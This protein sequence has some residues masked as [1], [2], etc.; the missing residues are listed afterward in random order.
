MTAGAL[1]LPRPHHRRRAAA[2]VLLL[3]L[4]LGLAGATGGLFAA[5]HRQQDALAAARTDRSASDAALTSAL[6]AAVADGVDPALLAPVRYQRSTVLAEAAR[7]T[8]FGILDAG[9]TDHLRT[10]ADRLRGILS[11]VPAIEDQATASARRSAVT[12]LD[13]LDTLLTAAAAAGADTTASA[14]ALAA[15]RAQLAVA[16]TPMAVDAVL[17]SVP[18]LD[19]DLRTAMAARHDD[20]VR[21]QLDDLAAA[22]TQADSSLGR[23]D[24]LLAEAQAIPVLQ[25]GSDPAT[26]AAA[27]ARRASASVA[28]DY[29]AVTAAVGPAVDDLGALLDARG[30]AYAAMADARALVA[31][32][33]KLNLDAAATAAALDAI[34]PRLDAAGTV[35]LLA[36][37]RSDIGAAEAP[38]QALIARATVG[39]G[40]VIVI[41][42]ADQNLVAYENGVPFLS[43]P[44]TTGQPALPTPPGSY[45]VLR[46]NSPWHMVS[47]YPPGSIG[48]YPPTWVTWVLWFRDD[49]YGIHDAPWRGTY[50]P[51]TQRYGSHGCV[52]VPHGAMQNLY[53]WADVGT[54]VLVI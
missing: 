20:V 19:A 24:R 38:L 40:R 12:A 43:S 39:L 9:E 13:A 28:D 46:K 34:Q 16:G 31:D 42:L 1:A 4:T 17:S 15:E 23:A 18:V 48:Y 51:G 5:Q 22:R 50:G 49:G 44:V 33:Q 25:L 35:P 8:R 10:Q 53:G 47:D 41:S 45:S 30:A 26:V 14:P 2:L 37:A 7:G 27:H 52:N 11:E 32:A 6:D 29:R 36:G 21:A 3:L 54:R